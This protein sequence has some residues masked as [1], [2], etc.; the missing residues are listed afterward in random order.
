MFIY[1]VFLDVFCDGEKRREENVLGESEYN[2]AK[3][4]DGWTEGGN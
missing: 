4:V 1:F 3:G 2:G